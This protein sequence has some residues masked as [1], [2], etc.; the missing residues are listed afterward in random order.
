M[1]E[2]ETRWDGRNRLEAQSSDRAAVI[3]LLTT[4]DVPT[5]GL[6]IEPPTFDTGLD[7]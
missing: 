1:P 6:E 7:L 4:P 5:T 2:A 3:E